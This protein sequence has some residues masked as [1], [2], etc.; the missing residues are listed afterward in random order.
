MFLQLRYLYIK[1][2]N[3]VTVCYSQ[4][5]DWNPLQPLILSEK[6]RTRQ[7]KKTHK[8]SGVQK[9]NMRPQNGKRFNSLLIQRVKKRESHTEPRWLEVWRYGFNCFQTR[10]HQRGL[11][12][13]VSAQIHTETIL[14]ILTSH[15][16][17]S[18]LKWIVAGEW[19]PSQ[20]G[21]TRTSRWKCSGQVKMGRKLGRCFV[22]DFCCRS[23]ATWNILTVWWQPAGVNTDNS[24]KHLW[25]QGTS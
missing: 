2:A 12:G 18:G 25:I 6:C 24:C 23:V 16:I 21:L 1:S 3:L 22:K 10:C 13:T 15:C 19:A 20:R 7:R 14:H 17:M 5:R 9:I 11:H 8:A 4:V